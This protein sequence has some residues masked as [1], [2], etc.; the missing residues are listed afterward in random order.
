MKKETKFTL[1]KFQVAKLKD[2]RK[3]LG[4]NGTIYEDNGGPVITTTDLTSVVKRCS[5]VIVS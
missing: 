5:N 1:E 3:I 2:M 4:E